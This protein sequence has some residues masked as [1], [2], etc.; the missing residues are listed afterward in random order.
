MVTYKVTYTHTRS[1]T[2]THGPTYSLSHTHMVTH[3]DTH[4]HMVIH[5]VKHTDI[6]T[7]TQTHTHT[8]THTHTHTHT[9]SHT[10]APLVSW[11]YAVHL[12]KD[13]WGVAL[14]CSRWSHTR[15]STRRANA[16]AIYIHHTYRVSLHKCSRLTYTINHCQCWGLFMNTSCCYNKMIAKVLEFL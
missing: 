7:V 2:H 16:Q 12:E 15:D 4:T 1:H 14:H 10:Q 11:R 8:V 5:T 9:Q 3:T 6:H 13:R